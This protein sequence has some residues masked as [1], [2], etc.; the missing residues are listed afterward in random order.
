MN[1]LRAFARLVI[2]FIFIFSGF[3]KI[4]D[5][6]GTGLIFS[7]YLRII[8]IIDMPAFAKAA[9]ALLSVAEFLT[10]I[11]ILLGLR[12][13]LASK[14]ALI[15]ISFFTTLTLFLAIF[16][17]IQDCGCFGE[18]IKLTNWQ[19][20]L[21][22]I[23]LL[24]LA[25]VVYFQR[26]HFLPIAP[27]WLERIFA[28]LFILFTLTLSIYSFINLPMIDFTNLRT[29]RDLREVTGREN[30]NRGPAF[31]TILVYKK[32]NVVKEFTI[33]SLP[34]STWVFV[35][36]KTTRLPGRDVS[37]GTH[38]SITDKYGRYVT[39]SLLLS[40]NSL[41]V[42]TIPRIGQKIKN[43]LSKSIELR[44]K[45]AER[46]VN[47]IYL[48]GSSPYEADSFLVPFLDSTA[49]IYYSDIK[50]VI[51]LNRSTAGTVYINNG[52]MSAKWSAA[53]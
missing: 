19:T 20:F 36:S 13:V 27:V 45:L 38:L 18:A 7:E 48:T 12:M 47:H 35:D 1:T 50:N 25:L 5:P 31:E 42:T 15:F 16:N 11:F 3:V 39:D 53:H 30:L 2:G 40:Q 26:R 32:G 9:G 51:T 6:A 24:A 29:G 28:I 22:N 43:S 46:G 52:V 4:I 10:G 44:K 49:K 33:D 23:V 14:V 41:F 17:P 34:D 21:K 37:G 8:G